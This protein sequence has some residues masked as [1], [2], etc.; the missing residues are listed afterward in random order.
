[1]LVKRL[2]PYAVIYSGIQALLRLSLLGRAFFD[3]EFEYAA[4]GSLLVR[5]AWF[6][7]VAASFCL[8]P[9]ILYYFLL[10]SRL[11]GGKSDRITDGVLRS[12]FTFVLLF[13]AV[14]EHLFWTEF[15][16]RFNFIAVDYLV[17]TQ[18]VIGNIVESYPLYRL[19]FAIAILALV[20]TWMSLRWLPLRVGL[21]SLKRRAC[22]VAVALALSTVFYVTSSTDQ[23]QVGDN[24][25]AS[26][27]AANGIYNLFSAFWNNEISY[28][29]FYIKQEN[30]AVNKNARALLWEPE[31]E[32]IHEDSQDITRFIR[33]KGPEKHKNVMLVVMESMSAEYMGKFGNKDNLTPNLDKLAEEGL[34][35]TQL[36]ATG[37][38]TV[39]GLEAVTLS[40]P[41]T[42]GQSII[43][44]PGNE[45]LFSLGFIFSDRGYDT[46]FIYGGYGYFDNMN[47]F[48][49]GN[50]FGVLDRNVMSKDEVQ[51]ANIWGV[52]DE[53]M[54][55]RSIKEADRSFSEGKPF[56]HLV[57][58]TSN[59]R[60]FTY[61]DGKIDILSHQGRKGGVKYADYSVGKLI[62]AAK[63]KPW[64]KDT[65]FVFVADH[66]AGA[67]GKA[68]LDPGKY[69]IPL[70][71]Y[72]PGFVKPSRYEKTA[73][74]ID[75]A[76]MLLGM[77]N[78]SYYTKFY[79]EDLLH[80][81][82]EVPHAFISNYQ[83]VAL[84]K[85]NDLIVLSPNKKVNQYSWPQ[86]APEEDVEYGHIADAITY[87]QSASWWKEQH[88]RIP[89]LP[90]GKQ[91]ASSH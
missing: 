31:A 8:L 10:P 50:G 13:D 28:D 36:Y 12:I 76:P 61:P 38:R 11:H 24:A 39:R 30:T 60:P 40:I 84:V 15:T 33:M 68:E 54:F 29:R 19:L 45:N 26:E 78:F 44:R 53:D 5:G 85:D 23:A 80:D 37:T 79:G 27:I 6:D 56:L 46:K 62:K 1:M 75:L 91:S 77:L 51:F 9:I 34:F 57:M 43:R 18:E 2:M 20:I 16:T 86:I 69:H 81:D 82:D 3:V 7:I 73:S 66:T 52:C 89:T 65:V 21:P 48:F 22:G 70:I 63:A 71:F 59:H 17:Y 14:A 42:P 72:A 88:K 90:E 74:Q 87:Y 83:K 67:G 35:F 25:E 41:P 4:L 64:F 49:A 32:F 58:T 47:A 55:T